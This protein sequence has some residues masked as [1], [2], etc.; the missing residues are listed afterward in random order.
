MGVKAARKLAL[1]RRLKTDPLA[2]GAVLF[3]AESGSSSIT[4][5]TLFIDGGWTPG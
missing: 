2:V 5:S 1:F 3:L 4:G